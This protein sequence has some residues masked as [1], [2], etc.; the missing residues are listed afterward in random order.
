MSMKIFDTDKDLFAPSNHII[1]ISGRN[2][3]MGSL[4]QSRITGISVYFTTDP[5]RNIRIDQEFR[6]EKHG[7]N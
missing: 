4:R 6:T 7:I 2:K 1:N 5:I 3:L